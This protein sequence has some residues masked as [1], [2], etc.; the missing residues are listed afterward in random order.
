MKLIKLS[1]KREK[2]KKT[3][4]DLFLRDSIFNY[5]LWTFFEVRSRSNHS[6]RL[7]SGVEWWAGSKATPVSRATNTCRSTNRAQP[8]WLPRPT[9]DVEL[10]EDIKIGS[11]KW[12]QAACSTAML[13]QNLPPTLSSRVLSFP[14]AYNLLIFNKCHGLSTML[15]QTT[16][17]FP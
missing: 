9:T 10:R 13:S 4:I 1:A 16:S 8:V 14:P 15:S 6:W 11:L 12:T 17:D 3:N 2:V 7:G 5:I